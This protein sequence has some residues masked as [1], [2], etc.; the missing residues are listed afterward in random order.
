MRLTIEDGPF[1]AKGGKDGP[2]AGYTLLGMMGA[3]GVAAI[4]TAMATIHFVRFRAEAK[5]HAAEMRLKILAAAI[6]Q[7]AWDTGEW[8]GGV[9]RS[10]Q[11]NRETW[12]L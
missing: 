1:R 12:N 6:E 8:P 5:V 9:D 11:G 7:L 10:I 4:L 3:V 2:S